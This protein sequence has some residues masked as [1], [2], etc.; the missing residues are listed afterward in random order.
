MSAKLAAIGDSVTE[1]L[2]NGSI[3]KTHLSYPALIAECLGDTNFTLP[4]FSG[5]PARPLNLEALLNHLDDHASPV[6]ATTS[7]HS[8]FG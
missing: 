8:L 3:S 7:V 4:D 1:G 5:A 6:R 2:L